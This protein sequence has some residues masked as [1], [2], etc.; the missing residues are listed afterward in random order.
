MRNVQDGIGMVQTADGALREFTHI[1]QR[2]RELTVQSLNDTLTA[3]DR[4][5]LDL[6]FQA[7][8]QQMHTL[9]KQTSWN[10]LVLL[11]PRQRVIQA[12]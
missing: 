4:D 8:K 6:E 7:L 3:S 5:S 10:T 2:M 1:A 9:V 12:A 11:D